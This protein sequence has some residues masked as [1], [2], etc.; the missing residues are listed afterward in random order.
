MSYLE[1]LKQLE[2]HQSPTDKTD[3]STFV[4][5]VSPL[6][7]RIETEPFDCEVW[8]ERAAE[9]H[10]AAGKAVA[11][12]AAA[13]SGVSPAQSSPPRQPSSPHHLRLRLLLLRPLPT[14]RRDQGMRML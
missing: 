14:T 5:S 11:T 12:S 8:K 10:D 3:R 6:P 9:K 1:R 2:A 7:V 13:R 4:S